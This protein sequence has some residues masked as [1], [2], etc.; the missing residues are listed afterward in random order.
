MPLRLSRAGL[1]RPSVC[2]TVLCAPAPAGV[3]AE[4]VANGVQ[5]A[6]ADADSRDRLELVDWL[7]SGATERDGACAVS[8]EP[9]RSADRDEPGWGGVTCRCGRFAGRS[10]RWGP[11]VKNHHRWPASGG[12]GI[13]GVGSYRIVL[14]LHWRDGDRDGESGAAARAGREGTIRLEMKRCR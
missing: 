7:R 12:N 2:V 13:G 9:D 6:R 10:V 14:A 5:P 4:V 1:A 3:A 8:G 11:S